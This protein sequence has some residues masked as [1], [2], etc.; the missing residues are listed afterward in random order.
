MDAVSAGAIRDVVAV[1]P[2]APRLRHVVDAVAARIG[3]PIRVVDVDGP[4]WGALTALVSQSPDA[5]LV[6]LPPGSTPLYRMHCVLHELGHLVRGDTGVPV[7]R[8]QLDFAAWSVGGTVCHRSIDDVQH[9]LPAPAG[10]SL[11]GDDEEFAETFAY[12]LATVL[13]S[14][15]VGADERTYG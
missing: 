14:G 2:N 9:T 10:S 7:P 3:K 5:A 15:T 1:L 11:Q 6:L 12:E 4:S 8:T 13:L